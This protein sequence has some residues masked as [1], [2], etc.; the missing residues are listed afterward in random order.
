MIQLVKCLEVKAIHFLMLQNT[1]S[2][3][4][5]NFKLKFEPVFDRKYFLSIRDSNRCEYQHYI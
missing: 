2:I 3:L 1:N 5:H 4:K